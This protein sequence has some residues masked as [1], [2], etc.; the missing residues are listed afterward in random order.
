MP[1]P[2][3]DIV[4][5]AM[6]GIGAVLGIINTLHQLNLNRVK[7]RVVPKSAVASGGVMIHN[8]DEHLRGSGPCIEVINL[9]AFPVTI[10]EVGYT[11]TGTKLRAGVG[12]PALFDGK[13]WPRR[14]EPR[15]SVTAYVVEP[16]YAARIK[17]AFART[18]CGVTRYG[19][20]PALKQLKAIANR[21]VSQQPEP[22]PK[23]E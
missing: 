11:L 21:M 2:W 20:S 22:G 1:V 5:I 8:R 18:E 13:P 3:K 12:N 9:S 14:L 4:T 19:T 17:K 7:L 15:E 10:S 23:E 16:R 6:A